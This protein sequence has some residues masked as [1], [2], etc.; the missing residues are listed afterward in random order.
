MQKLLLVIVALIF[1]LSAVLSQKTISITDLGYE[2][3]SR[4]NVVPFVN[5]AIKQCATDE[6]VT[7]IFPKGRYDFWQDFSSRSRF[8]VGIDMDSL[9]N[10]TVDGAGSEFIF[11]GN[12]QVVRMNNCENIE[13][14][15]FSV[16]WDQPF[17]YQGQYLNVTDDYIE[18]TFDDEYRYVIENE[19]FF[20]TGEGWK[21][22]PT[23][24]FDLFD[25][26]TKEIIYKT[27]DANNNLLF[28]SKAEEI[29]PGIV[30]FYG[31]P[32]IRP[33]KG[34]YTVLMAGT[35]MT[36]GIGIT[37][38]KDIYLKDITIYHALS[39]GVYANR[40]ENLTMENT[41]TT[42]NEKKGRVFSVIADASHFPNNKGLIK[43][44]NC[45]H[46]G[47]MDDF[48]NVYGVYAVIDS[49]GNDWV[50]ASNVRGNVAPGEEV[51]FVNDQYQRSSEIFVI[52][53][54]DRLS[55]RIFKFTFDKPLPKDISK[56]CKV[57]NKTWTAGVEIRNCKIL[58][59]HRAR[60]ILVS[61]P[62]K[63]IIED[64]Y[65]NT[66]GAAIL[67]EGDMDIWYSSGGTTDVT[68]R[69]N[70]FDN[71]LTS[72]RITDNRWEWGDAIIAIEPFFR[73]KD[74]KA[75]PYHWNIRIENNIFK[76][77][78]IPLVRAI[79]AGGLVFRNNEII[80]SYAYDP[81]L[82]Q[83]TSFSL[84]GCR[85][86]V[87]SGNKI[88]NQYV[89]RTIEAQNMRKSEINAVGFSLNFK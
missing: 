10:V 47:A 45:A 22:T 76:T 42:I 28:T 56:G 71:C 59:H 77:F 41:S 33:P 83:K 61:T 65:F 52:K 81:C 24:Y 79:S 89:T 26:D 3:G 57:E 7:I 23:G 54:A 55:E 60:G 39:H 6:S 75:E 21:A 13:L 32:N 84:D 44:I 82:M 9:T 8:S 48:I 43:V 72:G 70:I 2:Q 16:D 34:T 14:K 27:H 87:I 4:R 40:T 36:L 38:S 63:V 88:D 85:N 12:M 73:P 18:L 66:A 11:H 1:S 20:L 15:N 51:W 29:A 74:E 5:E 58:K 86:V 49:T 69:N 31:T 46:T 67:I 25:R 64:N 62:Q 17:M 80:R 78:D 35:Y 50:I 68:I 53:T 19:R 30:R 37:Y